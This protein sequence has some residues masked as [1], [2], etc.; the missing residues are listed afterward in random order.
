[1]E[2]LNEEARQELSRRDD[3]VDKQ[4][5]RAVRLCFAVALGNALLMILLGTHPLATPL[6]QLGAGAIAMAM[7]GWG[8]WEIA[9]AMRRW[10]S[11]SG[12]LA[13]V[14]AQVVREEAKRRAVVARSP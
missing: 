11:A 12:E 7:H 1:M 14:A 5:S 8:A 6:V 10:S 9:V 3:L 4:S 2:W 13:N